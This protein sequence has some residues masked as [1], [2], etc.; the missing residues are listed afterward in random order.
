MM[1]CAAAAF[2]L[3]ACHD[4]EP[5]MGEPLPPSA[6]DDKDW[7]FDAHIDAENYSPGDN[8]YM[9]CIGMWHKNADLGGESE[10]GLVWTEMDEVAAQRFKAL[11]DP[12]IEKF[13]ADAKQVDQSTEAA[14]AIVEQR[15]A[16]LANFTTKEEGWLALAKSLGRFIWALTC[17]TGLCW[18]KERGTRRSSCPKLMPVR[19]S[20]QGRPAGRPTMRS[21]W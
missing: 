14:E 1:C 18:E 8:F 2:F 7:D 10:I 9:Y 4:D 6:V 19:E 3:V 12:T 20:R 17:R 16:E 11:D 21:G 5:E 15:L 13:S